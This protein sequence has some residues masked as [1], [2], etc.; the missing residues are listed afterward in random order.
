MTSHT[1]GIGYY[2]NFTNPYT[3]ARLFVEQ[4]DLQILY[5]QKVYQQFY[6]FML[7]KS[8]RKSHVFV[9]CS[10]MYY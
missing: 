7:G 2:N 1:A 8:L 3:F 10:L 4:G 9:K 6:S 5:A